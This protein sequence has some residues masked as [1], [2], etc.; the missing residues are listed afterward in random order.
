TKV[1]DTNVLDFI[2]YNNYERTG[3]TYVRNLFQAIVIYYYD[4]FGDNHLDTAVIKILKWSYRIRMEKFS[5]RVETIE[6]EV[7]SKNSILHY[8]DQIIHS[9]DILKYSIS[10]NIKEVNRKNIHVLNSLFNFNFEE[11][12]DEK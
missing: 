3:D 7:Q 9:K 4:K 5:V 8:I 6:N 1:L 10:L 2:Y 12:K 11:L